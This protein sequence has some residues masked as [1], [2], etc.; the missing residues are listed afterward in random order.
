MPAGNIIIIVEII[1]LAQPLEDLINLSHHSWQSEHTTQVLC[2]MHEHLT[3]KDCV[4]LELREMTETDCERNATLYCEML[5]PS[6][7]MPAGAIYMV[8]SYKSTPV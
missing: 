5:K 6:P 8:V 4:I 2:S 7:I 3:S 1:K